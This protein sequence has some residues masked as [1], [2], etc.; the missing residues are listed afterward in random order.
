MRGQNDTS[1][2][3]QFALLVKDV[4]YIRD[5]VNKIESKLEGQ[6]LTKEEFEP[7]KRVMW[8]VLTLLITSVVAATMA[9]II[10]K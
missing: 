3:T 6:Y 9:L 1:E 2:D 10:K 8:L 5:Q 7:Y 4:S